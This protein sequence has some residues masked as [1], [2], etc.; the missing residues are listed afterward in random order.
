MQKYLLPT[1][2]SVLLILSGVLW[3]FTVYNPK[4]QTTASQIETSQNEPYVEYSETKFNN[5][6]AKNK[7]L[8]FSGEGCTSCELLDKDI[9]Q[10]ISKVPN[11]TQ[12]FKVNYDIEKELVDKYDVTA[13]HTL[14]IIKENN[15]QKW[16]ALMS[17]EDLVVFGEL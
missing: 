5:S 16:S 15:T 6:N 14:I 1:A 13:D 11:D 2:I 4:P 3:Y 17:L 8:F 10:Q 9:Q 12:I 7:I